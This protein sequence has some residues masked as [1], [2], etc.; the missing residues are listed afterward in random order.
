MLDL[1]AS[2]VTT[3]KGH[4]GPILA[5]RF[6][7]DGNYCLTCGQDR[8]VKLWNAAKGLCVKSY[9]GHGHEVFDVAVSGDN[10][11]LA[12]CGGDKTVFYWDVASGNTIRKFRG[13]DLKVNTVLFAGEESSVVISGSYDKTV[14]IFDCRSRS[15]EAMQVMSEATDSVTSIAVRGP[16]ILTGCVDGYLRRYDVRKGE[17]VSDCLVHPVTCVRFTHDGNCLLA[18]CM[19]NTVRLLDKSNGELLN[20]YTGH[21]NDS[22]K[23]ESSMTR[24]DAYVACGSED[25][26]ILFWDLVSG[27]LAHTLHGHSNIVCGLSYHPNKSSMLSCS[28]DGSVIYWE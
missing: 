26:R 7:S 1:P 25:G 2:Q 6:N 21:K 10:S 13:H 8:I 14:R 23:V 12:S 22:Y 24:G 15:F 9:L 20:S 4:T 3:F 28:V 17:M 18:T 11:R 19:D 27:K 5:V 16:E